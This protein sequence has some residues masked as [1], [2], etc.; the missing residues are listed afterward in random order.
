[1]AAT[2]MRSE[3]NRPA[4][5]LT[6]GQPLRL[7]NH[8][9]P[10]LLCFLACESAP[11]QPPDQSI[12]STAMSRDGVAIAYEAHGSGSPT[13]VLVHGWSCDRTYWEEQMEALS[14]NN[15]V[16]AL[17]L[18]G[19][20]ASGVNR[21]HWT[22]E[23]FGQDVASVA[24]TLGLQEIILVG[25][26]M[27][28]DVILEAARHLPG[29]VRGLVW[30]DTY[31]Q[32]GSPR[33]AQEVADLVAPFRADFASTTANMVPGMFASTADSA[34]VRRIAADMSAAPA[35]IAVEA[36][37]A[38]FTYGRQVTAPLQ[39][40]DVPIVA[41]NPS[42]PPTDVQSLERYGVD[43]VL[44]PEVGHFIML[45]DPEG[46]NSALRGVISRFQQGG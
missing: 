15:R 9:V 19:H 10:L 8:V 24:D 46:F 7:R 30:V 45:E 25:H 34:L 38:S 1:M 26:S 28:G 11:D 22:I 27:G 6:P 18:G 29:R 36:L 35:S 3:G 31:K 4:G 13:I 32:L 23:S 17:D 2:G 20:G 14:V 42:D 5:G 12:E 16:V 44:V 21:E 40:L 43:V 37:E 41:I 39:A 33:T